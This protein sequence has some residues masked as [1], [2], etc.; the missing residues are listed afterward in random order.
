[1]ILYSKLHSKGIRAS[2]KTIAVLS[3]D[4]EK[5]LWDTNVMNLKTPIGLLRAVF[6]CNGNNFCLLVG[7]EQRNIITVSER[8]YYSRRL[9]S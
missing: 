3:A 6:F 5:K 7:A 4:N 8:S 1:M 9:R 2:L